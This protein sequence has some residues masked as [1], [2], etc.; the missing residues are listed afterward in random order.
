MKTGS[1]IIKVPGTVKKGD[2]V[3]VIFVIIHPMETGTRKDKKTGKN[4]PAHHLTDISVTFGGKKVAD[5]EV[6][7]GVSKNPTFSIMLKVSGSGSLKID[8]K[9]NQGGSWSK[10]KQVDV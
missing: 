6:G 4:F 8:Y 2:V 7:P 1:A 10:S 9:D 3:K 5:I